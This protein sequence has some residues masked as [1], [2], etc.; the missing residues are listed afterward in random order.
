MTLN[1]APTAIRP[2]L[3]FALVGLWLASYPEQSYACSCAYPYTPSEALERSAAVFAGRVISIDQST[4]RQ[5]GWSSIAVEFD[6]STVWKGPDQRTMRMRTPGINNSC[7]FPFR[8]GV[9][10]LVFSLDGSNVG[11]CSPVRPI[12][13]AADDL[14][15]LGEGQILSRTEAATTPMPE[16]SEQPAGGGCGP[17]SNADG[18]LMVGLVV[19]LAWC[20]FGKRRPVKRP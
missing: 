10:Y 2:V 3:V 15:E 11:W 20:G 1:F 19:G 17:S 18:L 12:S 9:E 13:E 6:V 16:A 5:Q 14:A 8:E 4:A 7:H